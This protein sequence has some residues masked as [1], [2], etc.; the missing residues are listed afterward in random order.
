M[1]NIKEEA[2]VLVKSKPMY[3]EEKPTDN[4]IF[5][6]R[7]MNEGTPG[8]KLAPK[9]KYIE[10]HYTGTLAKGGKKFDSSRD[11]GKTFKFVLGAGQV[12]KCWDLG[13]A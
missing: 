3:P 10:M 11:R 9:G 7:K 12:I 1:E 2:P 4:T 8:G 5:W 13:V 6:V